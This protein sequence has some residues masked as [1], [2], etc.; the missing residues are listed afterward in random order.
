M[1][2][3]LWSG[4]SGITAEDAQLHEETFK[5]NLEL[6]PNNGLF[7]CLLKNHTAQNDV[8]DNER[9]REGGMGFRLSATNDTVLAPNDL[10]R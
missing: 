5:T 9:G 7:F 4:P 2:N 6:A 10:T 8:N 3:T 1:I